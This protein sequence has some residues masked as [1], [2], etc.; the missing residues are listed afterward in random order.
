[1]WNRTR[2]QRA[3]PRGGLSC[4]FRNGHRLDLRD[5]KLR[6]L[7]GLLPESTSLFELSL[8]GNP[9]TSVPAELGELRSLSAVD[10]SGA[11]ISSLPVEIVANLRALTKLDLRSHPSASRPA[12]AGARARSTAH[13]Q[14][15]SL[16]GY[17]ISQARMLAL[18][19]F[20]A[21]RA[22]S[23]RSCVAC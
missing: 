12:S 5:N 23:R 9:M 14:H 2:A 10:L 1:M 13:M 22:V 19:S 16:C 21:S 20:L 8:G 17:S 15:H 6:S 4:G 7:S 3:S 18:P 11:A